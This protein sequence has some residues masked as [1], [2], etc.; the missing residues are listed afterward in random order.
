VRNRNQQHLF[1]RCSFIIR[2]LF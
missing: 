2:R 1:W